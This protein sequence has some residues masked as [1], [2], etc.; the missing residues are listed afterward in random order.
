MTVPT[1]TSLFPS[2]NILPI[3]RLI[4]KAQVTAEGLTP[5]EVGLGVHRTMKGTMR[6]QATTQEVHPMKEVLIIPM[7]RVQGTTGVVPSKSL[8]KGRSLRQQNHKGA[9]PIIKEMQGRA[10]LYGQLETFWG[11]MH[12][13]CVLVSCLNPMQPR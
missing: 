6:A 8:M 9:H 1:R 13:H 11:M 2:S 4:L 12:P 5:T 10:L 7:V 3:H